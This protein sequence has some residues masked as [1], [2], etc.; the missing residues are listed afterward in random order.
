VPYLRHYNKIE[1]HNYFTDKMH[2]IWNVYS[3]VDGN[4]LYKN[5][6]ILVSVVKNKYV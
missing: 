1:T 5:H 6:I 4:L 3:L 2:K